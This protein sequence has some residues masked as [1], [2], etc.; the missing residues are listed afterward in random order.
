MAQGLALD[1]LSRRK[2]QGEQIAVRSAG[3]MAAADSPASAQA[4]AVMQEVYG[5]DISSHKS[6]AINQ[7]DMEK[8]AIILTMTEGHKSRLLSIFPQYEAKIQKLGKN[9]DIKD[10][11]GGS[12][13]VYEACAAEIKFYLKKVKWEDFRL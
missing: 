12:F 13:E 1:M 10:P 9:K 7:D 5:I 2:K 11:F 3:V 4:V 8:A 6:K